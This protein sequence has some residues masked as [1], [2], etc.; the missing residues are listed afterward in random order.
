MQAH[1]SYWITA[2]GDVPMATLK[3]FAAALERK[4]R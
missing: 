2:I 4:P 1:G 3:Q